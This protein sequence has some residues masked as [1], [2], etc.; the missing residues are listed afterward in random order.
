MISLRSRETSDPEISG[1]L[2]NE[3]SA[4]HVE[5][6]DTTLRDGAQAPHVSLSHHDKVV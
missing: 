6:I 1:M 2:K 3:Q 4:G 5:L